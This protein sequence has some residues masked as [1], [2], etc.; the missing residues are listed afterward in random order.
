MFLIFD[1]IGDIQIPI[2]LSVKYKCI[3]SESGPI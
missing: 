3:D 2:E 1:R